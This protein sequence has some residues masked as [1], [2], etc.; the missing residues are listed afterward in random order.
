MVIVYDWVTPDTNK[1]CALSHAGVTHVPPPEPAGHHPR[2]P[3]P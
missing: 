3:V 1:Y 2:S